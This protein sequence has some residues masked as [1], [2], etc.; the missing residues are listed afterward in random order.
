M[1]GRAGMSW[2]VLR[3]QSSASTLRTAGSALVRCMAWSLSAIL[4]RLSGPGGNTPRIINDWGQEPCRARQASHP[5]PPS[6]RGYEEGNGGI[7]ADDAEI[8]RP[9]AP[10]HHRP[11]PVHTVIHRVLHSWWIV[12]RVAHSLSTELSTGEA[13]SG[14]AFRSQQQPHSAPCALNPQVSGRFS[15]TIPFH[16]R[17]PSTVGPHSRS[18]GIHRP[19][20]GQP[21]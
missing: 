1:L 4:W 12:H 3:L 14:K 18:C 17:S 16:E 19:P 5:D 13:R 21:V 20:C 6:D 7:S 2:S 11:Q 10:I 8:T 15:A 9:C